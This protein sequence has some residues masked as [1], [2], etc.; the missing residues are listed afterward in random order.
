[1]I[2]EQKGIDV[3]VEVR[4]PDDHAIDEFQEENRPCAEEGVDVVAGRGDAR[5]RIRPADGA[6]HPGDYT[7]RLDSRRPGRRPRHAGVRSL[8]TP[9]FDCNVRA[10]SMMRVRCSNVR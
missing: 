9:P 3:I 8:R 2:V 1:V 5:S 7:I 6:A 10:G 4:D